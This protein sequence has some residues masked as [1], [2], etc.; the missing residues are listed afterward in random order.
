MQSERFSVLQ[1]EFQALSNRLKET[2]DRDEKMALLRD[3]RGV[4]REMERLSSR[5]TLPSNAKG[6]KR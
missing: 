3:M 2:V 4:V 5:I 6:S 1:A